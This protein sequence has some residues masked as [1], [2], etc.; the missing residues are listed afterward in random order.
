MAIN[1]LLSKLDHKKCN[2]G[3][4]A[5]CPAHDD[6]TPSL[7]VSVTDTGRILLKCFAGCT[8][9]DIVKELDITTADLFSESQ[10]RKIVAIYNYV[11]ENE[12]LLYQ[13][14]RFEPKGFAQRMPEGNGGWIWNLNGVRRVLYRLPEILSQQTI[15]IVEGEKDCDR[16]WSLGFPATTNAQG[17]GK[18]REE[19]T[20]TYVTNG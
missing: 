19:Y 13:V 4:I 7:S 16:L 11:D 10:E 9:S 14:V 1:A 5:R 20:K 18:W 12:I 2:N 15:Y 6:H 17:A 3:Y 8:V